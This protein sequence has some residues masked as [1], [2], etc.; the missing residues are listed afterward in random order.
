MKV[1]KQKLMASLPLFPTDEGFSLPGTLG[2]PN[3][4]APTLLAQVLSAAIGVL[5]IVAAIFFVFK[6]V[7][8]AIAI[9]SAGGDTG[10]IAKARSDITTGLVGL[11][12]VVTAMILAGFI[13]TLLGIPGILN[14]GQVIG[15]L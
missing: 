10:K 7:S 1:T 8:G 3:G 11:V 13:F 5:T 6:L 9:I 15:T 4:N 14:L 12:V 2:E